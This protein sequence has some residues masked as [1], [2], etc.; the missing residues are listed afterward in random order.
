ML[1]HPSRLRTEVSKQDT[2]FTFAKSGCPHRLYV[3]FPLGDRKPATAVAKAIRT[4]PNSETKTRQGS[5]PWSLLSYALELFAI[6]GDRTTNALPSEDARQYDQLLAQP[7]T[8]IVRYYPP[9]TTTL[10]LIRMSSGDET[11][12]RTKPSCLCSSLKSAFNHRFGRVKTEVLTPICS[13]F[14]AQEP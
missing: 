11:T 8:G 12:T 7:H 4:N 13:C 2:H 9:N 3:N 10:T 6:L 1:L 5:I 14:M